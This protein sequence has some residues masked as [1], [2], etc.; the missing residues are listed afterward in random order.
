VDSAVRRW[1]G[2]RL[3]VGGVRACRDAVERDMVPERPKVDRA[4]LDFIKG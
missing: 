2:A 4:V 1:A 3:I